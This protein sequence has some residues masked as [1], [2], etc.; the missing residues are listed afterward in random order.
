MNIFKKSKK[1]TLAFSIALILMLTLSALITATLPANAAL[2]MDIPTNT[3]IAIAPNP[4]GVGQT[5]NI[6]F[7]L[8]HAQP[9]LN[10]F[11]YYGWNYTITI[12]SPDGNTQTQG[13]IESDPVGGAYY[14]FT[15]DKV[16]E[17]KIKATFLEAK[18]NVTR[19]VGLM[20][21]PAGL[22]TFKT[23]SS[24]EVTL[25]VQTEQIEPWQEIPLPT[26]YWSNPISAEN[27]DWYQIAGNWL[28]SGPNYF[29]K[30]PDSPHILWTKQLTFG[31][32]TGGTAG[33]GTNFYHGLLYENKFSPRIISGRL[34]YN[35]FAS[36]VTGVTCADLRTGETIWSNDSMP[37]LASAQLLTFNTGVQTG[38]LAYLWTSS[39]GSWQ[40]YDA[41]TGRLLTTFANASGSP[42]SVYGPN[43]E[44][45]VY[46]LN[47]GTN[48][49]YLWNSTLAVTYGA[50]QF[51][52]ETYRPWTTPIRDWSRGIQW[53]VSVPDVPG[54]QRA[55][56]TNYADG[57]LVAESTI[58]SNTTSPTFVHVGYSLK[59]GS[60]LW[61]KNWTS[62]GWG[63]GGPS[64]P[65]LITSWARATGLGTY[66]FF[67][68]ETM[69][70]HVVD[71][72]T[73]NER[74]VTEPLNKFT[75]SDWSVYDWGVQ[76][77]YDKLIT[78]GYS[79][80]VL[81]FDLTTGAHLWTFKQESSGLMTPYGVWPT[82]GSVTCAD[83]KI[84]YGVTE[85]TPNSPMLRG[86]TLYCLDAQT[87]VLLWKLPAFFASMAVA[88]GILVGYNAYTNQIYA[89][90][91]GL[92]EVT[93]DAPMSAV[94]VGSPVAIRGTVTDQS[95]GQTAI[96]LPTAG[97][98]AISDQNM[99]AWMTYLYLQ[100]PMP[101]DIAGVPLTLYI[102]D[103]SNNVV[104]TIQ[105]TSDSLGHFAVSWTPT[106][107]GLY[108]VAAIFDGSN[109]YY[110]STEE[111]AIVVGA[112]QT[113][114]LPTTAPTQTASPTTPTTSPSSATPTVTPTAASQPGGI[115]TETMLIAVAAAIII[116]VVIAAAFL[117]RRQK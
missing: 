25:T 69:Q 11:D 38:T 13:P 5:M 8:D 59:D 66:A 70:W 23:S 107:T 16:G 14:L 57:V 109:S 88:D 35:T 85:H 98:P 7:W 32:I 80:D 26:G 114:T 106:T 40:M 75:N 10:T 12:V 45:L 82:F 67:E 58:T 78:T 102:T 52:A 30:A 81:A 50:T 43:G 112:A 3:Y 19:S 2:E 90:G 27:R 55:A 105:T 73:G 1:P 33:W 99:T 100:Q 20:T 34:Y 48:Q 61:R 42:G 89:F 21:L 29:T 9:Q 41:F 15:P 17:Y 36:G 24:R 63:P 62:V 103:Q 111:T 68:K 87:G 110:A 101:T 74:F 104:D 96:G 72:K 22:Y 28:T 113:Q 6:V 116:A 47:G 71:I 83:N 31:G 18:I 54:S 60:E 49:L 4:V 86:Y 51:N 94:S 53:N 108:K 93:V 79:G 91:K 117:L 95:P 76:M 56:F 37:Q 84:Y 64:S 77:A 65:T 115:P 92:S 97:T 44:I 39:G 46:S